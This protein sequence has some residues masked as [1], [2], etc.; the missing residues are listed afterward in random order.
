L[1]APANAAEGMAATP[2]RLAVN[3]SISLIQ[4]S[5]AEYPRHVTCFSCHHQGVP[6]LALSLARSHGYSIDEKGM[7]TALRHTQ[8]DLRTDIELY[9]RGKGQPG[10][11]T[12]AGYALLALQSGG[13]KRDEVTAAVTGFLVQRDNDLGAWRTSGNRPPSERSNFTD[14][15]VA[16]RA[17]KSF[18]EDFQMEASKQR[19]ERARK[20]LEQT[21]ARDTEDRV[22]RLWG[23]AE[24]GSDART[25]KEALRELL[26]QQREDGGW[27][28]LPG[29]DAQSPG[30]ASD[31]YATGSALTA[32]SMAGGISPNHTAFQRGI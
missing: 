31:A 30:G 15:F 22:F 21:P 18:G 24:S 28:Q 11:V 5:M 4:K 25:L 3:R 13:V 27:A 2:V 20:W 8:A 29:V 23:L 10:G 32:L 12:R 26:A 1:V 9:R 6:M 17:L 7:E 19:I 16:I 14:T